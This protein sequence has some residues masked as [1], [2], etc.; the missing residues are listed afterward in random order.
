MPVPKA[1]ANLEY[2]HLYTVATDLACFEV[3]Q[4]GL[5]WQFGYAILLT[6]L[7]TQQQCKGRPLAYTPEAV[8][9]DNDEY[10][11]SER[12][13][14]CQG[15]SDKGTARPVPSTIWD[16]SWTMATTLLG[17]GFARV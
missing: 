15:T 17:Y 6:T 9:D 2:H 7:S 3:G 1:Y 13:K 16:F 14:R 8:G 12:S 10:R 5:D 11:A 4:K